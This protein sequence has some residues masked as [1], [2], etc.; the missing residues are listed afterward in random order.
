MVFGL[1]KI[2][3][4]NLL[5]VISTYHLYSQSNENVSPNVI[6]YSGGS[7]GLN[8]NIHN[9][10]FQQL[11]GVANC[12]EK[13][14]SGD[15]FGFSGG[16]L[17]GLPL[18]NSFGLELRTDF[19]T[20]NALIQS[21]EPAIF[22][23]GGEP[24]DGEIEHSLD[25][26]MSTIG[27]QPLLKI[28]PFGQFNIYLG[29]RI[30]LFMQNDFYQKETIIKPAIEFLDDDNTRNDTSGI[31]EDLRGMN[32][33]ITGGISYNIPLNSTGS[34]MLSPEIFI[35]YGL[36]SIM[37]NISWNI[38]TVR[39][40]LSLIY[41]L[42]GSGKMDNRELE[43]M[44]PPY[45]DLPLPIE[46]L[47][48][49][50]SKKYEVS[51]SLIEVTGSLKDV[52]YASFEVP[53]EKAEAIETGLAASVRAVTLD[54]RGFENPDPNIEVEEFLSTNMR[55]ILNYIFFEA[56]SFEI[57]E[58]YK[59]LSEF[60][61]NIFLEEDLTNLSTLPTYYQ[62][63]N[64]IGLRMTDN[65][66][67]KI[68]L[69]GCNNGRNSENNSIRLSQKRAESISNYLT[70]TWGIAPQRIQTLARNLPEMPSRSN[71]SDGVEENQR[72]EIYSDDWD[73]MKPVITQDT[74][75]KVSTKGIRFYP[76]IYSERGVNSWQIDIN[77]G[78]YALKT[79]KGTSAP[80]L[81]VDWSLNT[82]MEYLPQSSEQVEFYMS[83]RDIMGA[84]FQTNSETI[85]F[86]PI[87]IVDK[88]TKGTDDIRIDRYSLILF[89]Y[90]QSELST[91][92]E[93]IAKIIKDRIG[94][95]SKVL[96][97]GYTDRFGDEDFN[98]QLSEARAK[99]LAKV[100]MPDASQI[101]FTR[102][103]GE[104]FEIFDNDLPEGRFYSRTVV[105]EVESPLKWK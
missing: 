104:T 37:N 60:G 64:I 105:V 77:H 68:T 19:Q 16:F 99:T 42:Y 88:K 36:N 65:S 26:K 28:N 3:L 13:F 27:I 63:L 81:N 8:N 35:D 98:R 4:L 54:D 25:I 2:L 86:K 6:W 32:Y 101:P 103:M 7:G 20:N 58:R 70:S 50:R 62:I 71:E 55:P 23:I 78:G 46:P 96:I 49:V 84:E 66:E 11:P 69:I 95:G 102:G 9:V 80:P 47:P 40:G 22:G 51:E 76:K 52:L 41:N 59:K 67:S 53:P 91:G 45:P 5:L 94:H 89:E 72:V 39:A 15:G 74:I 92:N 14:E 34:V 97:T 30:S 56:N 24:V 21:I 87:T 100:L 93:K 90:A 17:F 18:S 10:D 83:V 61:T 43:L 73:M 1:R 31:V 79:L 85:R 82:E 33:S 75:R 29:S 48:P 57:P 38:Y 44:P 12:C